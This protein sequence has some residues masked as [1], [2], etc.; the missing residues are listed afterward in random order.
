MENNKIEKVEYCN[1][2]STVWVSLLNLDKCTYCN[3]PVKEIGWVEEK[4][5]G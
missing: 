4:N 3:K 5:N 1:G 2:C